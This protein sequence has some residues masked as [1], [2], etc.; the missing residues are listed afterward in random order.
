MVLQVY[1]N[2][3]LL[4]NMMLIWQTGAQIDKNQLKIHFKDNFLEI[5]EMTRKALQPIRIECK[6]HQIDVVVR[7]YQRSQ[8]QIQVMSDW[9]LF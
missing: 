6:R 4:R 7:V 2:A 1:S 5:E 8:S 9:E 3:K